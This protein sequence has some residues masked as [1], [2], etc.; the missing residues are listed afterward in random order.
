[1]SVTALSDTAIVIQWG[2]PELFERNGPLTGY[3]VTL[4]YSNGTRKLYSLSG[5][6]FNFQIEGTKLNQKINKVAIYLKHAGLPKFATINITIAARTAVG[7]GP[8]SA[9]VSVRTFTDGKLSHG[10]TDYDG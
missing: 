5:T 8:S 9:P 3:E 4:T 1:M 6:T 2:A 10:T 7:I